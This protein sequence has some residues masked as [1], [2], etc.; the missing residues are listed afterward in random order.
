M[1]KIDGVVAVELGE[2]AKNEKDYV[3]IMVSELNISYD[4]SLTKTKVYNQYKST[5]INKFGKPDKF[6][7]LVVNY[8]DEN[9]NLVSEFFYKNDLKKDLKDLKDKVKKVEG[10]I[11]K[12]TPNSNKKKDDFSFM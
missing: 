4:A 3:N 6:P 5:V 11:N 12:M 9:N 1:I 2:I 10:V 8:N 7:C